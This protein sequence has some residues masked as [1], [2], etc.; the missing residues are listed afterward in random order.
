ME[1]RK[2]RT[3]LSIG[4]AQ[5]GGFIVRLPFGNTAPPELLFAGSLSACLTYIEGQMAPKV[6]VGDLS[7]EELEKGYADAAR[8]VGGEARGIGG[9]TGPAKPWYKGADI[10][11]SGIRDPE[12]SP[13]ELAAEAKA[14]AEWDAGVAAAYRA[15]GKAWREKHPD[16]DG[17]MAEQIEVLTV[18]ALMRELTVPAGLPYRYR[19]TLTQREAQ[20]ILA[21]LREKYPQYAGSTEKGPK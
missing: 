9:G 8:P 2:I 15:I 10:D 19:K 13:A 18:L 11:W 20:I 6:N 3:E 21:A 14:Q 1:D 4:A 12:V 5:D 7:R 16:P 17:A